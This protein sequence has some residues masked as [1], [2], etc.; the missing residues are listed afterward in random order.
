MKGLRWGKACF[1]MLHPL[2]HWRSFLVT[3]AVW[4]DTAKLISETSETEL[5]LKADNG[6]EKV[7]CFENK[8]LFEALFLVYVLW[9]C[10]ICVYLF[11]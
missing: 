7:H 1:S 2:P 3:I 9:V 4:H 11:I 6:H 8:T 5:L 10:G